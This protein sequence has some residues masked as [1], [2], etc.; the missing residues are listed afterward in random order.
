MAKRKANKLFAVTV[1][2]RPLAV[3]VMARHRKGAASVAKEAG[4]TVV[5]DRL[6][7]PA[8]VEA[9]DAEDAQPINGPGQ[10]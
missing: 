9:D 5:R 4:F 7:K 1:E 2:E 3:F 10:S 8:I 6:G